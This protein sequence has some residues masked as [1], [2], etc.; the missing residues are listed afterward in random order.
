V[1]ES[2]GADFFWFW[3]LFHEAV[4][5]HPLVYLTVCLIYIAIL[6]FFG[7][8]DLNSMVLVASISIA[9]LG[10][11]HGGL[12]HWTGRRLLAKRFPHRW[13]LLFFPAYLT[14]GILFG[15]GWYF[16]P[17][18]TVLF[19]VIISAWHFGCEDQRSVICQNSLSIWQLAFNHFEVTAVGGL[20][21]WIPIL[22]RPDEMQR[23][24]WLIVPASGTESVSTILGAMRIIALLLVPVATCSVVWRLV[25]TPGNLRSWVPL[26]TISV[27]FFAP[28]LISFPVYFCGW[29]SWQGLQRLR[30]NESLNRTEFIRSVAPL[31]ITAILGTGVAGWWLQDWSG[32][33]NAGDQTSALVQTLFIGLS[34][35]AVPHLLLHECDAVIARSG[36]NQQERTLCSL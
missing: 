1:N 31:S 19:F 3:Q 11:P 10:V 28:I 5:M 13:W 17:T 12:D 6:L 8:P 25:A 15:I 27:A 29:H 21:L 32:V 24:L 16:L 20:V 30:R 7:N 34:A 26:A 22:L 23:L 2:T 9:V 18:P 14:I 33:L 35:I 36:T 4:S